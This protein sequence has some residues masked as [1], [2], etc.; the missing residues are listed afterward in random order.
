MRSYNDETTFA[1]VAAAVNVLKL[2]ATTILRA[3]GECWV[4][5]VATE[6]Y[7]DLMK[8]TGISFVDFVK[9]LD[10]MHQRIRTTFPDYKPPSFRVIDLKDDQIQ[11]DYDSQRQSLLPFVEGLF[12]GLATHYNTN[13]EIEHVSDDS[14]PLPCKRMFIHFTQAQ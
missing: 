14:H 10:H 3:F 11:V 9:N 13:I 2:D 4:S 8:N 12:K 6:H 7:S 1:L 5:D